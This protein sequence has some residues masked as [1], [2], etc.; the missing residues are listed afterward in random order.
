MLARVEHLPCP[1]RHEIAIA[2]L[3]RKTN[4]K[5]QW[6]PSHARRMLIV[7][8]CAR[9]DLPRSVHWC[10]SLMTTNL[11]ASRCPT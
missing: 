10:Q 5:V 7:W 1:T 6:T 8:N 4:T 9:R 3:G 2:S 11:C